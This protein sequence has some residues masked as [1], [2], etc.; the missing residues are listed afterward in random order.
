MD[1]AA[2]AGTP[3]LAGTYGTVYSKFVHRSCGETLQIKSDKLVKIPPMQGF[4]ERVTNLYVLY[5]HIKFKENPSSKAAV[6]LFA[7]V[8]PGDV[9]GYVDRTKDRDCIGKVP[10]VH[11]ELNTLPDWISK[12]DE[13]INPNRFWYDGPGMVTCYDPDRIFSD[14]YFAL[15]APIAC[16]PNT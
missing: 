10:H 11:M 15:V 12:M 4:G 8:K 2:K 9:I 5:T 3:V 13:G 6:K 14:K 16:K 1:F 7:K